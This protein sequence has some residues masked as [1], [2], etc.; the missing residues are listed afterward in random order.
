MTFTANQVMDKLKDEEIKFLDLQFTG[1]TGRFHHTT[2]AA[3]MFKIEDFED[4]L[5]KLDG[6]SIRGF[7]HIHESDLIIRPDP[8]TYAIIPWITKDKTARLL[9]DILNGGQIRGQYKKD[10]RGI[11]KRA[12]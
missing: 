3:N 6:S 10:P 8:S 4:G 9:C 7:T 5:P 1:L 11:A 12:Q 2:M